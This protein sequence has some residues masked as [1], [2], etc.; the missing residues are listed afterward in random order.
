MIEPPWWLVVLPMAATPVVYLTRRWSVGA[1]LAALASLFTGLLAASL[2]STNLMHLAG[3]TFL[4]DPL[5]QQSLALFFVTSAVLYLAGWRFRQGGY[6][7]PLG[8]FVSGLFA[9]AAMSRH[10]GITGLIMTLAAIASVPI[11]QGDQT[12]S[13]RAAWRFLVFMAMA[14]PLILLAAWRV[15]LYREDAQNAMYLAQA[16]AFLGIG[17]AIWL[18]VVP[19]HSWLTMS[20]AWAPPVAGAFVL[21]GFP[22]MALVTLS[23]LLA[24][25]TWFT[26]WPQAG[27]L[28]LLAGLASAAVGGLMTAV[29]RTL[30]SAIGYAALFD[31]GC[32]LIAAA[33]QGN[34]GAFTLYAGLVTRAIGLLLTAVATSA[35]QAETSGNVMANLQGAARRQPLAVA[36]LLVGG[37]T[38]AGLPLTAAFPVRWFVLHDLAQVD[39]R[40]VWVVILAGVGVAIF[41]LR[42]LR[43]M[44]EPP[45]LQHPEPRARLLW[46]PTILLAILVLLTVGLGLFPEPLLRAATRL[47]TVYPLPHL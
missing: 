12:G 32:L 16:A 10:L 25:A 31:L 35:L 26:W 7:T 42:A 39:Q 44:L 21:I 15:D 41:Y 18:A 6:F 19:L 30:R 43:T 8:L 36:A 28:L 45:A 13:I 1:Y 46:L 24:E 2:P 27:R 29:Q 34:G 11:I 22:M 3:R 17:L 47:A 5:A 40:A 38:L 20:G 33:M 37:F 23:H 9:V 14:L 4:L